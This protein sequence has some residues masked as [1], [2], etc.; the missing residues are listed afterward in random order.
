MRRV[1]LCVFERVRACVPDLIFQFSERTRLQG[2][3]TSRAGVLAVAGACVAGQK[4]WF[5]G[6]KPAGGA[7][8]R[9]PIP[10]T[11]VPK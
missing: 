8:H 2:P 6:A 5:V 9:T 11:V 10:L 3:G 1:V 7:M 4:A